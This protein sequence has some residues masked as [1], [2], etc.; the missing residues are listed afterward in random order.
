MIGNPVHLFL[1]LIFLGIFFTVFECEI[2]GEPMYYQPEPQEIYDAKKEAYKQEGREQ[3][4]R[5]FI[6]EI[7]NRTIANQCKRVE[8]LHKEHCI[9][10]NDGM[11]VGEAMDTVRQNK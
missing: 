1:M 5:S 10:I 7:L 2:G 4:E 11:E 3:F 8:S 9:Y 6:A